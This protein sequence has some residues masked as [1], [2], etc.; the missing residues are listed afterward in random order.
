MKA[1]FRLIGFIGAM[2]MFSAACSNGEGTPIEFPPTGVPT[3][4]PVKDIETDTPT[5]TLEPTFTISPVTPTETPLVLP[6]ENLYDHGPWLVF[7]DT[8][9]IWALNPDGTGLTRL[10]DHPM[11]DPPMGMKTYPAS[12][13]GNVAFLEFQ[14]NFYASPS[15][16]LLSITENAW[17]L[18]T[19]PISAEVEEAALEDYTGYEDV[20]AIAGPWSH[21]A[22]SP[23]G[24]RFVFIGAVEGKSS[25]LFIFDPST[26]KITRLTSDQT[27]TVSPRWSPDNR[28][29]V[30]SAANSLNFGSSGWGYS[31]DSFW[32][33]DTESFEPQRLFE[34]IVNQGYELVLD[35]SSEREFLIDTHSFLCP[36][37]NLRSVNVDTGEIRAV[38]DD[39]YDKRAFDPESMTFAFIIQDKQRN[40][41]ECA[42][43]L[44]AGVYLLDVEFSTLSSIPAGIPNPYDQVF[45][46]PEA[47]Q[48]FLYGDADIMTI[49]TEGGWMEYPAPELGYNPL[50]IAPSGEQWAM[51]ASDGLWIGTDDGEMFEI[52][53]GEVHHPT[54][55]LDGEILFFFAEEENSTLYMA[56]HPNYEPVVISTEIVED[57]VWGNV[58]HLEWVWP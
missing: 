9:G 18:I 45:W 26:G 7:N 19:Q 33:I 43:E 17:R 55:S 41:P 54:W 38:W 14:A 48:F 30:Y 52:Y 4:P 11:V 1:G 22:W 15:L 23:D 10:V 12:T 8:S 40:I 53:I 36:Y 27:H 20:M 32:A 13:G 49:S 28:T 24:R 58:S 35:W 5:P 50:V 6:L 37:S 16:Y 34:S 31:M 2:I 21:L 3:Q 25:D 51:I 44:E 56:R 39:A 29:I 42:P 46:S 47:G 57:H